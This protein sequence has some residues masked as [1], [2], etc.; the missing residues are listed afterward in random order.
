MTKG[1]KLKPLPCPF[2]GKMPKVSP[3]RPD[4][5]GDAWGEVACVNRRCATYGPHGSVRVRDGALVADERGPD[6]YKQAAI[7]RWNMRRFR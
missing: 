4:I 6:A 5:E 1:T 7:R 3:T 2:C